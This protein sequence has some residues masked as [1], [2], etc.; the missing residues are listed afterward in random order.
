MCARFSPSSFALNVSSPRPLFIQSQPPCYCY[1]Y[2]VHTKT[3][4]ATVTSHFFSTASTHKVIEEACL[5]RF[6]LSSGLTLQRKRRPKVKIFVTSSKT[7]NTYLL[8]SKC[9]SYLKMLGP[10]TAIILLITIKTS[11]GRTSSMSVFFYGGAFLRLNRVILQG[12]I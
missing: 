12:R 4:E 10:F 8:N 7:Q 1:C 9:L 11:R 2:I 6:S 5:L 3:R